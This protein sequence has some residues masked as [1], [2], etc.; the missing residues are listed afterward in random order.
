MV[1]ISPFNAMVSEGISKLTDN[2]EKKKKRRKQQSSFYR[3]TI[4]PHIKRV[5]RKKMFT[6]M[7]IE[8]L[9]PLTEPQ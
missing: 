5:V 3:I 6:L 8:A 7:V 1:T 2:S 4:Y 9:L